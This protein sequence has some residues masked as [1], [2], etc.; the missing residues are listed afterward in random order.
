MFRH[1]LSWLLSAMLLCLTTSL[2]AG[3]EPAVSTLLDGKFF[4]D[5]TISGTRNP[6]YTANAR[7]DNTVLGFN[8]A[9]FSFPASQ[10]LRRIDNLLQLNLDPNTSDLITFPFTL[11]VDIKLDQYPNGGSA[12]VSTTTQLTV[13]YDPDVRTEWVEKANFHFVNSG[14]ASH[15]VLAVYLTSGGSPL[16]DAQ[17]QL[18]SRMVWL[19]SD[20]VIE[21]YFPFNVQ[22]RL[23]L[24]DIWNTYDASSNELV[25][26]WV[27]LKGAEL[28][29]LEYAWVDAYD[30]N[31][32]IQANVDVYSPKYYDLD[33]NSTRI[34]LA[35]RTY[36]IPLVYESGYLVY[37]VRGI[38]KL[39]DAALDEV[40]QLPGMWSNGYNNWP[41]GP[42]QCPNL[43]CEHFYFIRNGHEDDEKNWQRITA[44]AE[45]AKRK[46][47]VSY[48]D[49]T[50]RN[51][52]SVTG[53]STDRMTLVGETIYDHQG[54]GAIQVL[55]VP[56]Q[57]A[58][59]Q[60]Y[61]RFN[62]AGGQAYSQDNFDQDRNCTQRAKALSTSS[63]AS[64]YYSPSNPDQQGAQAFL[65]DA[66]GFPW[67]HTEWTPDNTGR[68]RRQSGVGAD[69]QLGSGHELQFFYGTPSQEEISRLFGTEVGEASH[70]KKN[71]Q[72]DPNGQYSLSIL[73]LKGNIVATALTGTPPTNV[74]ALKS[75]QPYSMQIDLLA[76]NQTHLQDQA[77]EASRAFTVT[78]DSEY[79]FRYQMSQTAYEAALCDGKE[80][81]LDCVYDLEIILV[82]NYSCQD[83]LYS[84]KER[85]GPF[86]LDSD[87]NLIIADDCD[88]DVVSFDSDG[89]SPPFRVRLSPGSYTISKRL[90]VNQEVVAAYTDHYISTFE[91]ECPEVFEDILNR[92]LALVDSTNCDIEDDEP[93]PTPCEIARTGM[94][95][96]VSPGGQYGLVDF[97]TN[98]ATAPLS[99][100]NTANDLAAANAH[101]QNPA[102]PYRQTDGSSSLVNGLPPEQLTLAEFIQNWQDS[103]AES[104]LPYHPEYC[105]L[106]WCEGQ[107][108]SNDFDQELRL[109]RSY[110][111]ARRQGYFNLPG[112]DPYFVRSNSGY[113]YATDMQSQ[114]TTY[115]GNTLSMLQVAVITALQQANRSLSANLQQDAQRWLSANTPTATDSLA[116]SV[117]ETFRALYLAKKEYYQYLDRTDYAM[118]Q[119][120][121][122][123]RGKGGYNECIG[124]DPFDWSRNGFGSGFLSTSHFLAE[125]QPCSRKT[126]MHY[127]NKSKRFP[128]AYDLPGNYDPYGDPATTLQAGVSWATQ[129]SGKYCGGC[130]CNGELQGLI[131]GIIQNQ[132][133]AANGGLVKMNE[134]FVIA[135][136]PKYEL[137]TA[138]QIRSLEVSRRAGGQQLRIMPKN[139]RGVNLCPIIM[140]AASSPPIDWE[141]VREIGC[142]AF[143]Y[144][145]PISGT[146]FAKATV[147]LA[148]GQGQQVQLSINKECDL[149]EDCL[150]AGETC[151]PTAEA[152]SLGVLFAQL[153]ANQLLDRNTDITPFLDETLVNNFIGVNNNGNIRWDGTLRG[154]TLSAQLF[155]GNKRCSFT[156]L[157][158]TG[159]GLADLGPLV[160]IRPDNTTLD[161]ATGYTKSAILEVRRRGANDLLEIQVSNDCF[162]FSNCLRCP[163]Q[164]GLSGGTTGGTNNGNRS[165]ASGT[166]TGLPPICPECDPADFTLTYDSLGTQVQRS[167][168]MTACD[169]CGVT[170]DSIIT[171]AVPNACLEQ[172]I[173]S[174]QT[175][176]RYIYERFLDSLR[177]D[178]S[179]NYV[180]HC[181]QAAEAFT[182]DFQDDQHHFT[183]YYY[184]QANNLVQTIPPAGVR[185]LTSS[186]TTQAINYMR[187]GTGSPITPAHEMASTY[188]Y[189][190]LNQLREQIIPDYDGKSIFLFDKLGRIVCSQ[191]AEQAQYNRC[192]YTL[193]DPLGRAYEVGELTGVTTLPDGS[194]TYDTRTMSADDFRNWVGS[195][196]KQQ[197]THSVY[198]NQSAAVANQHFDG[199]TDNYRGRIAAVEYREDGNA[200]THATY[201]HYD[202]HGNVD[203]VVQDLE[204]L[205]PKKV[206]Y[207]YDLIS[208]N[209][210]QVN[211]QWGAVDQMLQRYAYDADNRLIKAESSRD[212]KV[213]DTEADYFYYQHGP[214]ARVE[215]GEHKVQG[216]DYAYT[217]HGWLKG[218][219]SATLLN[220]KPD[221][222]QDGAPG[223]SHQEVARD[224]GGYILRYYTEDYKPISGAR[225]EPT[226]QGTDYHRANRDLRNGNIQSMITAVAPLPGGKAKMGPQGYAF[227]YDQLQRITSARTYR[228]LDI[229]NNSWGAGTRELDDYASDYEFDPNGNL[230][231]LVRNGTTAQGNQLQMDKLAYAY[232]PGTNRLDYV[233]DAVPDGH[234]E[235]D[236]D[237]QNPGNYRY[238]R[239][240]NLVQDAADGMRIDWKANGK[241][242]R[243]RNNKGELEISYDALGN[244][245]MKKHTPAGGGRPS[246]TFYV[247]DATGTTLA[248]YTTDNDPL[249]HAEVHWESAYLYGAGRLAEAHIDTSMA[250]LAQLKKDNNDT[251]YSY[252]RRGRKY[253]EF[254]EHRSNVLATLSDRK[255]PQDANNDR[256]VD[257][258]TADIWS[259]ADYYPYGMLMTAR[260]E[261]ANELRFGFQGQEMDNE[262]RGQG[263][264]INYKYRMHDPRLGR[265][266]AVDPLNYEYPYNSQYAFSENQVIGA[267]EL[268]GLEK[269]VLAHLELEG[270]LGLKGSVKLVRVHDVEQNL[271]A[272]NLELGLGG[273]MLDAKDL[274]KFNR[275][276]K[277]FSGFKLGGAINI[278]GGY[279]NKSIQ[280]YMKNKTTTT[281][282]NF[283]VVFGGGA[284]AIFDASDDDSEILG[285]YGEF[286]IGTEID[287]GGIHNVYSIHI[288]SIS[289]YLQ[290]PV[291]QLLDAS[292]GAKYYEPWGA[293]TD[294][295][296]MDMVIPNFELQNL[297][298]AN[299]QT[300]N[301]TELEQSK[302]STALNSANNS[303]GKK[304]SVSFEPLIVDEFDDQ[305]AYKGEDG[306][307]YIKRQK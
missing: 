89:L 263:N 114:V 255:L 14:K 115:N 149:W 24:S 54:R 174:A 176:A 208:G 267:V 120:S 158:P 11:T 68:V 249:D 228:G 190:S 29:D 277:T 220:H 209:V 163:P 19:Q 124:A 92:Q 160:A 39:Y 153:L 265:F 83:T 9:S 48:F 139:N 2:Q 36:R 45:D 222:G 260:H 129:T 91:Q 306:K 225:W 76:Y 287:I 98:S 290:N 161:P 278:G 47:V 102:T 119:C 109:T 136:L 288:P 169:A 218:V 41:N 297:S 46:D 264:S 145:E 94:L 93:A 286:S 305:P 134:P 59:L 273:L 227:T 147:T 22:D 300:S 196:S 80:I 60:F 71:V 240:G 61:D 40:F 201:Y 107:R 230:L 166:P 295:P 203:Q 159:I 126:F 127:R 106:S 25:L 195:Y 131:N 274:D 252:R 100:F 42:E 58:T 167:L 77:L 253:Y 182:V 62:R 143:E 96:D 8:A 132:L 31:G 99:V 259:A 49:G 88:N 35:E 17:K 285:G 7:F 247:L 205:A 241:V 214:L 224:A 172:Q 289:V 204:L 234:Y 12:R 27:P 43:D 237:S 56:E 103:W 52:Q 82:D 298:F 86:Q 192:A 251:W 272:Y 4:I 33:R 121:Y 269:V 28:Y 44:F 164:G 168:P 16:T 243:M 183:L 184:D 51:R 142:I 207:A 32:N 250:N 291:L 223:H 117:W 221:L 284:G 141:G 1:P 18:V 69:H 171:V 97:Q 282:A 248:T 215:L 6:D 125:D 206:S 202:I 242:E 101:W 200:T 123:A 303:K 179:M 130:Q 271:V 133:Y 280:W 231:K 64:R 55:P 156:L 38:G 57:K 177:T 122:S 128:S 193:Y 246:Y 137:A 197:V 155:K 198:D 116:A 191:N 20:I 211:Y 302:S 118:K 173:L 275:F 66:G 210:H 212:G 15:E 113:A 70:Y 238:D 90:T 216:V 50:Y 239:I 244:R 138:M 73:D 104:L 150:P 34:Q 10:Q 292:T 162:I 79:S 180:R 87:G 108:R 301:G 217:I 307:F 187:N 5:Y 26:N 146:Y 226:Y 235:E 245:V 3:V 233:R 111:E 189:T 188:K 279:V 254:T 229:Q 151:P 194:G 95:I 186:Q 37:R 261:S 78:M 181:L 140:E 304:A 219:N 65:P 154:S 270:G 213:W 293:E 236:I 294:I 296:Y 85:L 157:L 84:V 13:N 199:N 144:Q 63:G 165:G 281:G 299:E 74:D 283:A 81:C 110:D 67:V 148:N 53:L 232:R 30:E 185:P 72:R 178:F 152:K 75:Y 23:I 112:G 135:A 268:E 276:L 257:Y 105:Y 266:F 170:V 258:Y 256:Q 21:R 262:L 175:N